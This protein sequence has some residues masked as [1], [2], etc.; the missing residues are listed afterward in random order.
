MLLQKINKMS[1]TRLTAIVETM[2]T[3]IH[4]LG[5]NKYIKRRSL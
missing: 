5:K 1:L 4:I 2:N 3:S